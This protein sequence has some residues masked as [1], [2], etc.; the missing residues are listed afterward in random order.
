MDF[1]KKVPTATY[2]LR[3]RYVDSLHWMS[4]HSKHLL[5]EISCTLTLLREDLICRTTKQYLYFNF[6]L[7]KLS[8]ELFYYYYHYYVNYIGYGIV[9][10]SLYCFLYSL[11]WICFWSFIKGYISRIFRV[12]KSRSTV[13]LFRILI[14]NQNCKLF[15]H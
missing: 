7:A 10:I 9:H 1:M 12:Q 13:K 8:R 11:C 2:A 3:E 4:V 15:Q 6:F 5:Y 14:I